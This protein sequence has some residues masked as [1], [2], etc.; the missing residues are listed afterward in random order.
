MQGMIRHSPCQSDVFTRPKT[1]RI[2]RPKNARR[3]TNAAQTRPKT[4]TKIDHRDRT[5]AASGPLRSL[6]VLKRRFERRPKRV[7]PACFLAAS[8][9]LR[10]LGVAAA[11]VARRAAGTPL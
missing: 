7:H 10:F 6:A 5:F 11:V 3:S 8:G 9:R 4:R 2:F 1:A